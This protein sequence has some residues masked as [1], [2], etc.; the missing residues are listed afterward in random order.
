MTTSALELPFPDS[1][2]AGVSPSST[3][4]ARAWIRFVDHSTTPISRESLRTRFHDL[5]ATW[6][7]ERGASSSYTQ[8]VMCSSYQRI[9]GL[10]KRVVPLVFKE[11]EARPDH[12]FWALTALTGANPV[13]DSS[14]GN[15][16][17]MTAAWL[18]W[19]K[20]QGYLD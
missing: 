13:P 2:D 17:E 1:P 15:L 19:G 9:I 8:M 4:V 5:A 7:E 3:S 16:T 11:M 10:G 20:G 6:R 12:W 18:R 14:A